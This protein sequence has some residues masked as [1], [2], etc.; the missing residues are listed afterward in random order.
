LAAA[1]NGGSG[2]GN[3]FEFEEKSIIPPI[4]MLRDE[5]VNVFAENDDVRDT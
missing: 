5:G 4:L 1:R 2:E 3:A